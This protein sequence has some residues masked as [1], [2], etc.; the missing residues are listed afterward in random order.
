MEAFTARMKDLPDDIFEIHQ[1]F[2]KSLPAFHDGQNGVLLVIVLL[3]RP[4]VVF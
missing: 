1:I 2:A 3:F 4:S